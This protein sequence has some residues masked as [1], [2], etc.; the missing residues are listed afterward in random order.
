LIALVFGRKKKGSKTGTF[1]VLVLVMVTVGMTLAGCRLPAGEYTVVSTPDG[2]TITFSDGTVVYVTSTPEGPFDPLAVSCPTPATGTPVT[3]TPIP[4]PILS[5]VP[6]FSGN[7]VA[8]PNIYQGVI[9]ALEWVKSYVGSGRTTFKGLEFELVEQDL[10]SWFTAY[11]KKVTVNEVTD[12]DVNIAR[13]KAIHELGHIVDFHAGQLYFGANNYSSND[14]G[15]VNEWV[16]D[17][18]TGYVYFTGNRAD[19]ASDYVIAPIGTGCLVS[20]F[21]QRPAALNGCKNEDFAES[22]TWMVYKHKGFSLD[23]LDYFNNYQ[24]PSLAR[25]NHVQTAITWVP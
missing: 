17:E 13:T 14:G 2:T 18:Q 9:E 12:V 7:W 15:W 16:R 21:D 23:I 1:L 8:Y 19:L 10:G 6:I 24:I 25:Q 3:S 5:D 22:F 4:T 20:A 11:P